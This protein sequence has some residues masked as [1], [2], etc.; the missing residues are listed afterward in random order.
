MIAGAVAGQ[1]VAPEEDNFDRLLRRLAR[2]KSEGNGPSVPFEFGGLRYVLRHPK[3]GDADAAICAQLHGIDRALSRCRT[4]RLRAQLYLRDEGENGGMLFGDFLRPN[5]DFPAFSAIGRDLRRQALGDRKVY[6]LPDVIVVTDSTYANTAEGCDAKGRPYEHWT[7]IPSAVSTPEDARRFES[8]KHYLG[9][10]SMRVSKLLTKEARDKVALMREARPLLQ[11][12][13]HWTSVLSWITNLQAIASSGYAEMPPLGRLHVNVRAL[14][15]GKCQGGTHLDYHQAE[16]IVGF[17]TLSTTEE[18]AKAMDD[19]SNPDTYMKS[20]LLR[21]LAEKKVTSPRTIS[22][23]WD[24][25]DDLDIHVFTPDGT[26]IYHAKKTGD[27]C[28]L[29]FDANIDKKEENPIENVSVRPGRYDIKVNNYTRRSKGSVPFTI[30]LREVGIDDVVYHSHWPANQSKGDLLRVCYHTFTAGDEAADA[31]GK[32]LVMSRKAAARAQASAKDWDDRFGTPTSVVATAESLS[33]DAGDSRVFRVSPPTPSSLYMAMAMADQKGDPGPPTTIDSLCRRAEA[34][35]LDLKVSL[36]DHT[37]GY[38][39]FT[40]TKTRVRK[41]ESNVSLC[42]YNRKGAPPVHPEKT[43][44]SRLHSSWFQ[45]NDNMATVAC[46]A[47]V[48]G[49]LFVALK[50][51]KLP[52]HADFPL[53]GGFY[54]T[55]LHS[56]AHIHRERWGFMHSNVKPAPPGRGLPLIG[57]FLCGPSATFYLDGKKVTIKVT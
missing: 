52:E 51:A 16:N 53:G 45:T 15:T 14:M 22:L 39:V 36:R 10:M 1:P 37:P 40:D 2:A 57:A 7:V 28:T 48:G 29:D 12:S 35:P 25:A 8:L 56:T 32:P 54:P 46:I 55:Q 30:I 26:H 34:G 49:K 33:R 24:T 38:V 50:G 47:R 20:Q 23:C 18:L 5:E 4:C 11:R 3:V 43:G 31:K 41:T 19:R 27:G 13:E 6:S 42:H 9:Y 44:S 17:L 21:K